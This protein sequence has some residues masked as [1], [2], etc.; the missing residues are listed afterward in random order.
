MSIVLGVLAA[1]CGVCGLAALYFGYDLGG[2]ERGVA[3][4][5]SGT[6]A[7]SAG[8]I[9]IGLTVLSVR[10]K[11]LSRLLGR[12]IGSETGLAR[13]AAPVPPL[14]GS[15]LPAARDQRP[16]LPGEIGIAAVAAAATT[17]LPEKAGQDA[18]GREKSAQHDAGAV[19]AAPEPSAAPFALRPLPEVDLGLDDLLAPEAPKAAPAEAA[20]GAG[21]AHE[22]HHQGEKEQ[23]SEAPAEPALEAEPDLAPDLV[24]D[25]DAARLTRGR[26]RLGG[27]FGPPAMAPQTPEAERESDAEQQPAAPEPRDEPQAEAGDGPSEAA[28]EEAV[29]EDL[30]PWHGGAQFTP[31]PAEAEQASTQEAPLGE[32]SATE[33]EQSGRKVIGSYTVGANS[34]TMYGDGS[35]EALTPN[36][37]YSF[38]S[39]E[40][41]RSFI[42]KGGSPASGR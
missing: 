33:P 24:P 25:L 39:L 23:E 41:L 2:T 16:G 42:E 5:V 38:A 26:D 14:R 22:T 29:I 17:L 7:A 36:G 31:E 6:I 35:V 19:P 21:Q 32:E 12:E 10:L 28:V 8:A 30:P 40:E 11:Q 15:S 9:M 4:T 27:I 3:Y 18:P 34:Y 37:L 13:E 20:F 1:L